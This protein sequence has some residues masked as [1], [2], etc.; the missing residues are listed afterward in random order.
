VPSLLGFLRTPG[1]G[2]GRTRSRTVP[3]RTGDRCW[4]RG[5]EARSPRH[6]CLDDLL[7]YSEQH[8]RRIP[9]E[10]SRHWNG[11][12]LHQSREQ[13]PPLHEPGQPIDVT[14]GSSAPTSSTA[15]STSI[16]GRR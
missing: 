8:L 6:E 2:A 9:T 5:R 13:L 12:R 4:R 10:Y 15:W 1:P 14:A 16:A 11:H 7:V 3:W